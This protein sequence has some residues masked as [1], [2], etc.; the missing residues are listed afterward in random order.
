MAAFNRHEGREDAI[1]P[2]GNFK[3]AIPKGAAIKRMAE[4]LTKGNKKSNHLRK[5]GSRSY[6][7]DPMDPDDITDPDDISR[8]RMP[9][10]LT[11]RIDRASFATL[12]P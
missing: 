10:C 8:I 9:A 11:D 6:I 7:T 1:R 12:A 5:Q 2:S 4:H 3:I